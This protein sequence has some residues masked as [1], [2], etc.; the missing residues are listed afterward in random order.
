[1]D[2]LD[3]RAF[4]ANYGGRRYYHIDK[5]HQIR[6]GR[7]SLCFVMVDNY[8]VVHFVYDSSFDNKNRSVRINLWT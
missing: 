4:G 6:A 5:A 7:A 8:Y 1:M 3:F 2:S